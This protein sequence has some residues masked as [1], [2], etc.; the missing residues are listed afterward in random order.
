[1]CVQGNAEAT[2]SVNEPVLITRS[3]LCDTNT[4]ETA[5]YSRILRQVAN[6]PRIRAFLQE[7]RK[8]LPFTGTGPTF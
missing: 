1:V 7:H 8:R 3:S 2:N 6:R 5:H 4:N